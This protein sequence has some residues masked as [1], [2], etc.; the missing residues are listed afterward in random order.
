MSKNKLEEIKMNFRITNGCVSYGAETIL[1]EINFEVKGKQKVAIVGRNG[2]GKSTLLKA[3][4]NNE[5]LTEGIGE[6]KF[7]IY[8]EGN[9][10]IG[11]LKQIDFEDDNITML[12]EILKVYK[13]IIDLEKKLE[14]LVK[15][16]QE[17]SS[18]ELAKEYSKARDRYEF[19]DGYTYKKEYE[20]AIS[21]FG[22]SKEDKNKKLSEFSGGQRT[23]IAFIKLLL[24]KPDILLLDE[25]TN[26]LDIT[27][28]EWLEGY[29]KNYSKAVVI[30]SHDRM[31]L[32]KIVDKVY[33]I[34]YGTITEY[35]GNYDFFEKQ[36]R[37]NY[38]RAL[39]DFEFQQKEIK[40]LTQIADRFRYKPTKAK[41]A[42]SK[43][44]QIERMVKLEEP[45]KYDLKTFKTNFELSIE[46]GNNVLAVDNLKIGYSEILSE[47]SFKLYKGQ[48]LGIIGSNGTGKSTLLKTIVGNLNKLGGT[49]E[50][51]HNVKI[52]YFD[53]QMAQLNSE[54]TV[55]DEFYEEFPKLTVTE[56]RNSLAAFMFYGEDVFKKVSMLSGGEKVRLALCKILKTGPNLLILDEPTNHMDIIGKETLE[57]MLKEYKGTLIFVSHDRFFVN[58]IADKILNFENGKEKFYDMGYEE[59]LVKKSQ[60]VEEIV[61]EEKENKPKKTY[62]NPLKEKEKLERKI[63]KLEEAISKKE[64][65][66]EKLKLELT[67]EEIYSDYVK[68][69]EIQEEINK[70][71]NEL[72]ND[73]LVW[74]EYQEEYESI[75]N[76]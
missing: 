24:S 27:T 44:K 60:E 45:N 16:M 72:E 30:V 20:T 75:I 2:S 8:K 7:N 9:P 5:L 36:K 25:P 43:L 4:I 63:K 54:K 65:E 58:K 23:K 49:F 68:V 39:K 34:E 11:Y 35:S 29:L 18:E 69:G 33:E 21:K 19:L 57:N 17:D 67:K 76:A 1:E 42:L 74:E 56:V 31:F 62:I 41:M 71:N 15:K 38:E 22:F 51:G 61:E 73:M 28:I 37:V 66:I 52:G 6:E 55:F 53:Q 12:D 46:S 3:I 64:E 70:L 50:I 47:V 26:H 14:N 40:R 48:K 59:F 32:N 13:D 10:V